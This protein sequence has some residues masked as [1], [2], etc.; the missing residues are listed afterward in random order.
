[1]GKLQFSTLQLG[2]RGFLHGCVVLGLGGA[3]FGFS[4]SAASKPAAR[5]EFVVINGWVL[6]SQYFRKVPA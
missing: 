4:A 5:T 6:P 1:M 3:T 2:R